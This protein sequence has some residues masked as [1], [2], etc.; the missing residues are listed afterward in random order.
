MGELRRR[1]PILLKEARE[2]GDLYAATNLATFVGHLTRLAADDPTG[3]RQEL[4]EVIRH[5]SQQGFH[6][7]HL[8]GLMG[9]L[10]IDLYSGDGAAA[11]Q[12]ISAEWPALKRSLFLRV[13]TVRIFML[14]LRARS[15]LAAAAH[16]AERKPLLRWAE[17]DARRLERER[18][19]WADALARLIRAGVAAAQLDRST[20]LALVNAATAG[21]EAAHMGLFAAAARR[22][23]G[24]LLGGAEGRPLID[25]AD[26]WMMRQLIDNPRRMAALHAPGFI[27]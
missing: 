16:A 7:Q 4:Q 2:R 24:E 3:A 12:R 17:R 10:Q 21:F 18:M 26:A 8:T 13:Q 1:L 22:R 20:A 14:D 11:W 6:V 25:Q 23:Q 27:D 5:W 15:A 19:P 9:H